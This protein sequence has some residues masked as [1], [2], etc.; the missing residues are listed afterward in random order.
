MSVLWLIR[1]GQAGTRV[2]YDQLSE[3]GLKQATLLGAHLAAEEVRFDL[4]VT[5]ALQRQRQ[6][7]Q[8]AVESLRAA[9][10]PCPEVEVDSRWNEFDLDAVYAGIA[11]Q[12][13][14]DDPA[15]RAHYEQLQAQISSGEL[16]IHR[17]WTPA[18]T[19][20]VRAW[21]SGRYGYDGESWLDFTSRVAAACDSILDRM[22]G[23]SNAA[24]FTSATPLAVTMRRA[25]PLEPLH[26]MRLAGE[27]LN[28]NL[29]LLKL[30]EGALHLLCFNAVP[31]LREPALRT[32]R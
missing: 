14:R 1:H 21:V 11:P 13:A 23:G 10:I 20:I 18:D 25:V 24:V 29:T 2:N 27:S 31:H 12:L 15:F 3:L 8:L 22:N 17:R 5:G 26:I 30:N 7:A 9:G 19:G 4:I 16:I 28:T 32:C 6:T